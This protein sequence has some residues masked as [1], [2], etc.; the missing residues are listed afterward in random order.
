MYY[1]EPSFRLINPGANASFI[2]KFDNLDTSLRW[3]YHPEVELVYIIKGK[4]TGLVGDIFMEFETGDLVCLGSNLPHVFQENADYTKLKTGIKPLVQVIQ[5]THSFLGAEF[6][7]TPEFRQIELMLKRAKR[8]IRFPKTI[9]KKISS[10]LL[11]INTRNATKNI[12]TLLSILCSLANSR[13]YNYIT[14]QNYYFDHSQDEERM[15]KINEYIYHHFRDKIT[16]AQV[17]AVANMSE[18]SF[19]RYFKTRTLK[20]FTRFLNEVRIAFACKLLQKT[21]YNVSDA[22]FESGFNSLSYF[23]RQFKAIMKLSP[24]D[25]KTKK[26]SISPVLID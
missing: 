25:Y 11:K 21:N 22:C 6:L 17:A 14:N 24:K 4:I 19:C 23:N 7:L 16:I 10:D 26:E 1:T 20:H 13:K 2:S 8:G 18:N 5:F 3:H 9:V 12:L 15:R